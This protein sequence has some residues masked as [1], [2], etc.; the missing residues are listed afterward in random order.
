[1]NS[2]GPRSG[3]ALRSFALA[4]C[5]TN[6]AAGQ[7]WPLW[8]LAALELRRALLQEGADSFL[9]VFA[10]GAGGK[11]GLFRLQLLALCVVESLTQQTL[12]MPLGHRRGLREAFGQGL[13]RAFQ[14]LD[15]DHLVDD[16][17]PAGMLG[18][19]RLAQQ[20]DVQGAA[21]A[22]Q[23]WQMPAGTEVAAGT[24]AQVGEVEA[25]VDRRPG[26]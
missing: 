9:K 3:W 24:Q 17:Q 10:L 14:F 7:R 23:A 1:M 22:D 8:R 21:Q 12:E 11:G 16:A 5:C 18:I 20:G 6:A 19:Q 13:G 2:C 26:K 25:T 15:G 4:C